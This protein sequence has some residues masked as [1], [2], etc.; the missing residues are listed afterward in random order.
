MT[1]RNW[2]IGDEVRLTQKSINNGIRPSAVKSSTI[3][4]FGPQPG[5]AQTRESLTHLDSG[6]IHT[7]HLEL[8]RAADAPKGSRV[9]NIP[10]ASGPSRQDQLEAI[11]GY[12]TF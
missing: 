8:V 6:T 11:P 5:C 3:F 10:M 2:Q 9:I 7:S 1:D 4:A 12:G